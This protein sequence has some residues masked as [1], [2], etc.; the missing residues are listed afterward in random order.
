MQ[1]LQN[2]MVSITEDV[3]IK[4]ARDTENIIIS[5]LRLRN[6]LLP[7]LKKCVRG[8]RSYVLV[9]VAFLFLI[10]IIIVGLLP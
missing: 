8:T 5:D 2:I 3:G 7:Q 1:E 9:S 10:S 4:E 6:I